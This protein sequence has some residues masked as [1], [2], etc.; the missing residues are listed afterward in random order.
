MTCRDKAG[1]R[2][3]RALIT[4]GAGFLGSHLC[5]RL[6]VEGYRVFCVDDLRAGSLG[7]AVHFSREADFEYLEHGVTTQDL[8]E[9]WLRKSGYIVGIVDDTA[10]RL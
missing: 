8:S 2:K 3:L 1:A 7:N 5:E 9:R 6:L 10:P 4:G